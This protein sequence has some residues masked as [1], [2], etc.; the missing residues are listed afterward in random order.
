MV[1]FGRFG[2]LADGRP[3]NGRAF[4]ALIEASGAV[5]GKDELVRPRL[6]KQDRRRE[7]VVGHK[8]AALRKGFSADRELIPMV[9]DG[10]TTSPARSAC[11]PGTGGQVPAEAPAHEPSRRAR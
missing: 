1:E 3:V 2:T 7:P 9:A 8:I 6:A 11:S 5:V 4:D 10:V